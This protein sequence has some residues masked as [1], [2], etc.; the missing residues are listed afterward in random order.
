MS[1]LSPKTSADQITVRDGLTWDADRLRAYEWLVPFLDIPADAAA[2]LYMT[3]PTDEVV[4]SYG[5]YAIAWIEEA[6][7]KKLRW[8]QKL[9]I[10][11]QLEHRADGSLVWHSVVESCPRRAGKSVRIRG[12]ALW[13]MAHAFLIG[14]VQTVVHCGNDLP[15][16]REI[17]RGAWKWSAEQGWNVTKANG[18]EAIEADDGSR[19]LVRSQ[20]GVYGWEAGLAVVDE[21]WD[22]K[23]DTV[24]EGLEP[25]MLERLWSQLHLTSTAHRRATSLMK[26]RIVEALVVDDGETLLMLWGAPSGADPGDPEV[27]KAANPHWSE[28]R[29][30][31]MTKKYE[32]ALAGEVDP[33]ADDLDPMAGF[34]A[35]YLNMWQLNTAPREKGKPISTKEEWEE[36]IVDLPATAP[37]SAAIESWF[38][39]GVSLAFAWKV[40]SQAIVSVQDFADLEEAALV[41]K[42]SRFRGT[43]TVGASLA[44]DPALVGIRCAKGQGLVIASVREFQRLLSE[45]AFLHDGGEELTNQVLA[46]RVAAGTDGPR[47][48]SNGRADAIKAALWAIQSCRKKSVGRPRIIVSR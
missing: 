14:E 45:D 30:R 10:V 24:S 21:A 42:E 47:M 34:T 33:E 2:P 46:A 44:D 26:K 41:L 7:G 1:F 27:W 11:R 37:H 3:P 4:G 40:D 28:D 38:A 9:A 29:R 16:C 36:R 18:K 25:A 6:E 17:Q 13:R 22:V 39:D 31:I 20:E 32:K 23:P 35:Q 43:V 8:W 12:M 48:V 15:I 5:E 19:W